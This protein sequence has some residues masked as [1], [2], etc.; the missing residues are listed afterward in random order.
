M[1]SILG[2]EDGGIAG[3]AW[4]W[5]E[6]VRFKARRPPPTNSVRS[7]GDQELNRQSNSNLHPI[8]LDGF[9]DNA[10]GS[11]QNVHFGLSLRGQYH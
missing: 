9:Q 2:I 6:L 8:V 11:E 7:L 1:E 3:W 4:S 5:F 10:V